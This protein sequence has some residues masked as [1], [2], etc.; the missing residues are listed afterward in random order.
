MGTRHLTRT[1]FAEK[2]IRPSQLPRVAGAEWEREIAFFTFLPDFVPT[3]LLRLLAPF[4][5]ALERSPLRH[6]SAH[7]TATL[8]RK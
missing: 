4:E 5:R 2:W 6:L 8:I 3:A 7:Y 1:L